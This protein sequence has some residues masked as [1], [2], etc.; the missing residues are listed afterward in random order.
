MAG[1][2]SVARRDREKRPVLEAVGDAARFDRLVHER[3]RLGMLSALTVNQS[4][5]FH[6]AFS[7][8]P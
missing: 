6:D 5:T 3:L 8:V 2:P 1:K 4:L 7:D